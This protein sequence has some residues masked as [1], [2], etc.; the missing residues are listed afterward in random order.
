MRE[1]GKTP[2]RLKNPEFLVP[3]PCFS[4]FGGAACALSFE[5]ESFN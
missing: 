3:S 4:C 2:G 5:I 1:Q